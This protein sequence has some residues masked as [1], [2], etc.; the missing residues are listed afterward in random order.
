MMEKFLIFPTI[1]FLAGGSLLFEPKNQLKHTDVYYVTCDM[2]TYALDWYQ[3]VLGCLSVPMYVFF[4]K[5][6]MFEVNFSH[7]PKIANVN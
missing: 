7:R 3:V 5:N 6:D 4:S 1:P 2:W